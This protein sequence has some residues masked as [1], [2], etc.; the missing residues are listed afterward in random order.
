[1]KMSARLKKLNLKNSHVRTI[2]RSFGNIDHEHLD[3]A[4]TY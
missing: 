2:D 3:E 1:M 4:M